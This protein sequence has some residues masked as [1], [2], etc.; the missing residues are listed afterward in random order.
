ML[1]RPGAGQREWCAANCR[2]R[3]GVRGRRRVCHHHCR[4]G[5]RFGARVVPQRI[6]CH[7]H[8]SVQSRH[9]HCERRRRQHQVHAQ[10]RLL[11]QRSG[12]VSGVRQVTAHCAVRRGQRHR[13]HQRRGP[14]R[15]RRRRVN[16][17]FNSR[18][19]ER[20]A[21]RRARRAASRAGQCEQQRR[22]VCAGGLQWRWS[23]SLLAA[24]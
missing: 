14:H 11:R 24:S 13:H 21:K 22:A 16:G 23:V 3:R 4:A 1:Q 12:L 10:H 15:Q 7:H 6:L 20:A 5:Q 9:G 19:R 2:A 18:G 17:L 8:G